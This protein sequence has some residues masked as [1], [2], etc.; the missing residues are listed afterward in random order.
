MHLA[1]NNLK[2][3]K[4]AKTSAKRL[5][6]GIG[7]GWGKTA[8]RGHK[9]QHARK[10]GYHKIGFEGG[11]TPLQ[12][13]LRKFGFRSAKQLITQEVTLGSLERLPEKLSDKI[14]DLALLKAQGLLNQRIKRVKIIATGKLTKSLKLKGLG[15]T[16]GARRS[17][18]A[19]GGTIEN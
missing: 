1:L 19:L 3:A 17:V 8:G 14:I 16:A 15:V 5:G 4:G 10:G 2:P 7:S 9:G 6:R 12:R 18:E 13:S 11:Q